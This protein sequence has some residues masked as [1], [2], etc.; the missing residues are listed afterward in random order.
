VLVADQLG[1]FAGR[2][3]VH[4]GG[5]DIVEIGCQNVI[6]VNEGRLGLSDIDKRRLYTGQNALDPAFVYVSGNIC[7]RS[8]LDKKF[9]D[10]A[11]FQKGNPGFP[12]GHIDHDFSLHR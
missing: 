9:G 11:V 10:G 12:G 7:I 4:H 8:P 6:D 5:L 1:C 3:I 2:A